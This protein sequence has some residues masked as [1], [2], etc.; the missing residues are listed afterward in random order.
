[1]ND[2]LTAYEPARVAPL[3]FQLLAESD[4]MARIVQ[5]LA[6]VPAE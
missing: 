6:E 3:L 2:L 1:M 5:L 4:R